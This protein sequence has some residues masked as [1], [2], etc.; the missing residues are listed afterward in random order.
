MN[1]LPEEQAEWHAE[2]EY[3]TLE[4]TT[5]DGGFFFAPGFGAKTNLGKNLSLNFSLQVYF[6]TYRRSETE[7]N[8][9]GNIYYYKGS[10][11]MNLF[12]IFNIG[13][14]F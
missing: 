14:G 10:L 1:Q 5:Y 11:K 4:K 7:K 13:V 9:V 6:A 12:P 2:Y 8:D 3:N